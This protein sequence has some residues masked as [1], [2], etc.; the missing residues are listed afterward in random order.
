MFNPLKAALA[1]VDQF[2]QDPHPSIQ[3]C[4]P[5]P[6]GVKQI[7]LVGLRHL[8]CGFFKLVEEL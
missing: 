8:P 4:V 2:V 7:E 3:V 1:L 6:V 5:D